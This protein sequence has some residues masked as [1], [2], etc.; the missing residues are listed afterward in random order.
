MKIYYFDELLNKDMFPWDSC[1]NKLESTVF[2]DV[3]IKI[4][5]SVALRR[6]I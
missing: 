4:T 1:L 3:F 6:T 2:E 5:Q